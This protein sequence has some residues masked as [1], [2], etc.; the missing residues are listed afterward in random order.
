MWN[1]QEFT[2]N[3]REDAQKHTAEIRLRFQTGTIQIEVI[4]H[5]CVNLLGTKYIFVSGC[6]QG[7]NQTLS[8]Y[9]SHALLEEMTQV[10]SLQHKPS[11]LTWHLR[12]FSVCCL[13][14][15]G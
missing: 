7:F 12:V 9:V 6:G 2:C 5:R 8:E 15:L 3:G 13:G 1:T 10:H 4:R 11:K 14:I